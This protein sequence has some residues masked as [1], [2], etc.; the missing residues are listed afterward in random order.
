MSNTEELKNKIIKQIEEQVNELTFSSEDEK[1]LK[2]LIIAGIKGNYL[3]DDN[4]KQTAVEEFFKDNKIELSDL[5]FD[6]KENIHLLKKLFIIIFKNC[7]FNVNEV[8]LD[9]K[10]ITF[11]DSTFNQQLYVPNSKSYLQTSIFQKCIFNEGVYF[12]EKIYE[13]NIFDNCNIKKRIV[14]Y[15]CIF[16]GKIFRND[17]DNIYKTIDALRMVNCI[18]EDDFIINYIEKGKEKEFIIKKLYLKDCTF[19]RKV[20]LFKCKFIE[21]SFYNTKFLDLADFYKSEFHKLYVDKT[22]DIGNEFTEIFEKTDFEGIT[23]FSSVTFNEVIDFKYTKFLDNTMFKDTIF[24]KKIN[25]ENSILKGNINFFRINENTPLKVANRETARIIKDSFEQQNNIIEANKFYALE[26]KEREKELEIDIKNGKNFFE[27]LVFCLHGL[28]SNHSQDW[29]LALFWIINITFVSNLFSYELICMQNI[30]IVK[31]ILSFLS[32]LGMVYIVQK[33]EYFYR[34]IFLI[35]ISIYIYVHYK[36]SYID[37][38]LQ[39]F[40]NMINPFSIMTGN[41]E[42]TFGTLIYKII[43]G[44][45]IYQLIISIR[46]NTRRK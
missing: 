40:S 43:I 34:N 12:Y 15:G 14:G 46:Q 6:S 38:N 36:E 30:G 7:T 44:Y 5:V 18:F 24:L 17:I 22:L 45:L 29:L 9:T 26:M 4:S 1:E 11:K 10:T 8:Y 25:L 31:P 39:E 3:T 16:K 33:F 27:W 37:N 35:F 23:V 19:K 13:S 20:K 21:S 2:E 28:S 32:L 42:L 41:D